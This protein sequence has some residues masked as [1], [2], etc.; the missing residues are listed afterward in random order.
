MAEP[1][2]TGW[3]LRI[4]TQYPSEDKMTQYIPMVAIL[5]LAL[6]AITLLIDRVILARRRDNQWAA[7]GQQGRVPAAVTYARSFFPFL[8]IVLVVEGFLVQPFQIPS[9]SMEPTLQVGDFI[10]VNKLAY[11]V[12]LPLVHK[13][14]I[15]IADPERGDVLVFRYPADPRIDFIKR[16]VGLPGDRIRYTADQQLY[17]NDYL[18]AKQLIGRD[19]DATGGGDLYREQLGAA[20][21]MIRLQM[22]LYKTPPNSEWIVPAGHYFMMGDNRDNSY[23]SRYWADANIPKDQL[24]MVPDENIVGEA[25]AIV[26]SWPQ[27]RLRNFPNLWRAGMIR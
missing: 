9:G 19:E 6:C 17:V 27:P 14:I 13:K 10:L 22:A 11:G 4:T 16:V 24:G 7:T 3:Q 15:P 21:H 18:V 20:N 12:R 8:A 25:F 26:L 1:G 2:E 5:A 23:D